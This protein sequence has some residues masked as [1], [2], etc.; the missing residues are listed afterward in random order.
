MSGR[1]GLGLG[2]AHGVVAPGL[3]AL[4]AALRCLALERCCFMVA[5]EPNFFLHTAQY[6][7]GVVGEAASSMVDEAGFGEAA[8]RA[9]LGKT[10]VPGQ[11]CRSA[12]GTDRENHLASACDRRHLLSRRI[13]QQ[14]T[15][16][17]LC[18]APWV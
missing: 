7:E 5:S 17:S 4:A 18:G 15:T 6:R 16:H 9:A 2:V 1:A 14:V 3:R 10:G 12:K 8:M 11:G 13:K